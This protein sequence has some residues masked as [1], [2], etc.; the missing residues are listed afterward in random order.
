MSGNTTNQIQLS[1]LFAAHY[2]ATRISIE[3]WV[4]RRDQYLNWFLFGADIG[5]FLS[6]QSHD[7]WT[8]YLIAPVTVLIVLAYAGAD[9]HVAYLCR[10][11]NK[12][13]TP[14]LNSYC[15]QSQLPTYEPWHWDNSLSVKK[16]YNDGAGLFRYISLVLTF[17]GTNAVAYAGYSLQTNATDKFLMWSSISASIISASAMLLLYGVRL[18]MV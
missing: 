7:G 3:G 17:C 10:W 11:L 8:L 14:I 1:T 9:L 13:Y 12:E 4:N 16:F 15:L 18:R 2:S 6:R 5:F